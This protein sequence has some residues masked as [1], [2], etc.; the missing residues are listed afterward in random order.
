MKIS[1]P[2]WVDEKRATY[3]YLEFSY[4]AGTVFSGKSLLNAARA[5][6]KGH[7]QHKTQGN[8]MQNGGVLVVQKGGDCVYAYASRVAGDMAPMGE[9]LAAARAA[10]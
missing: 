4:G 8:P 2:I 9:V 1:S 5:L 7:I 10:V 3:R 6:S